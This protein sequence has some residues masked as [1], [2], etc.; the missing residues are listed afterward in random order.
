ME[1]R[2]AWV[3]FAWFGAA[4][5]SPSGTVT[6]AARA[7][8]SVVTHQDGTVDVSQS[9][10]ATLT[11]N[12]DRLLADY[13]AFLKTVSAP[14]SNGLGNTVHSACDV[15]AGLVPSARGVFLTITHRLDGSV[16][17]DTTRM[18]DHVT[19]LYRIAGG[20]SATATDPGSCGGGEFNRM[21]MQS[22]PTLQAAQKMANAHQGAQP[23][24]IA[25]VIAGGYWRDSH[26]A[27]GP[28]APFDLSDE[29]NDGAPRGQTQ[30]FVD[31]TSALANTALGRQDLVD[32]VDPYALE[33][34]QD[35]DCTHNSNPA[36]SYTFYGSLCAP[37]TSLPGTQLYSQKY[38]DFDA[39]Y[40]PTGC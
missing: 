28:H 40:V 6:D 10:P 29:T 15:W 23:Y 34:D 27:G 11:G 5:G 8:D 13:A 19:H 3:L 24:D 12:R 4:C 36:C 35:Y 26:D 18:L 25:D 14:Q 9:F 37:E 32:L 38:G 30:Y 17:A 31:P 7:G 21:I 20:E 39:A 16:L 2:H 33:M 1:T 22:D